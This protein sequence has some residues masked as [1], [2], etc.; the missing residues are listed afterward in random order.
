M[1]IVS[2]PKVFEVLFHFFDQ[3]ASIFASGRIDNIVYSSF[4]N[5]EAVGKTLTLF[6]FFRVLPAVVGGNITDNIRKL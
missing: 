5:D 4:R 2:I 1:P 3:C 6:I